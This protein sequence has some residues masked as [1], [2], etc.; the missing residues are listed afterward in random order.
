MNLYSEILERFIGQTVRTYT[1]HKIYGD[2]K[3]TILNF[4]HLC[5]KDRIGFIVGE[6]EIF[7]YHNE[8]ESVE[9]SKTA[10]TINGILQSI[11]IELVE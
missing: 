7:L 9:Q 4:Q 10:L 3:A 5:A 6:Q 2:H 1:Y 11:K 8:I